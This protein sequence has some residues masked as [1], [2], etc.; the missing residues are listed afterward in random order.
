VEPPAV[1]PIGRAVANTRLYVL[2][3]RQQ[4]VPIGVPG[5]LY[6]AGV[7]VGL[8]YHHR[9][10]LTAERF[11]PDPYAPT[12]ARPPHRAARMYRTGDRARWRADG[13]VEYLGR[14]DFQ[15][16]LRGFRI[17][18]GEIESAL[19]ADPSVHSAAVIVREDVPGD[20]RLVA[21]VVP[22][23]DAEL[24]ASALRALLQARLPEYMVPSAFVF[25]ESLPLSANGKLER[26]SL[27]APDSPLDVAAAYVAPRTTTEQ[28]IA[29]VFA[30]VLGVERVGVDDDFFALGGHSLLAMRA[31][32]RLAAV[33]PQRLTI[34][35]MFEARTVARLAALADAGGSPASA[36]PDAGAAPRIERSAEQ[37]PA[38]RS[39]AQQG[40]WTAEQRTPDTAA[41]NAPMVMRLRGALDPHAL[42]AALGA[43]VARHEVLRTS[44][45]ERVGE[46][47]Q[48][49]H[50][51]VKVPVEHA[52]LRGDAARLDVLLRRTV[53]TPFAL[54][55]APLIRALVARTGD[56][57]WVVAIVAHH[58]VFDGGSEPLFKRDLAAAYDAIVAGASPHLAPLPIA[59]ADYAR[60][61]RARRDDGGLT[62]ALAYWRDALAGAPAAIDL[63]SDAP[64]QGARDARSDDAAARVSVTYPPALLDALH[65]LAREQNATMFMV[66]LAGFQALLSRFARQ[67]DLVVG[68][69][70][71][72]RDRPE[73]QQLIGFLTNTLPLRATLD[74]GTT[75]AALVGQARERL[76]G[77]FAHAGVPVERVS[78]ELGRA[79]LFDTL[80]VLQDG[81][82]RAASLAG[83]EM[84]TVA[85]EI[86]AAKLDLAL[87]MTVTNGGLRAVLI[88]R[89]ARFT[90][91]TAERLLEHLGRLL[92]SA[93]ESP[94]RAIAD[95]PLLGDADRAQ[96]AAWNDT[97]AGY[98]LDRTLPELIAETVRRSPGTIA[99][100]DERE[101]LTYAAL[102]ARASQLAVTLRANG[103]G[104]GTLVGVCAERSV[105]MVVGLLAILEAGGAYVPIDPEYPAERV[106]YMLADSDVPVLLTQTHLA[107]SLPASGAIVLLLDD[108]TCAWAS[109]EAERVE[110]SPLARPDDPA[111]MIYTSGSTGQPKGAI[112]SH[113]GIVNRLAWMQAEYGLTPDDVV[114]QKTPFSFDVSVWEFF[115]PL[116][117]GARLVLAR[118]GG[119]RDSTYLSVV[120]ARH[121]VTVCHFVPSMLRVFLADPSAT[122]A[123]AL[124][125]V[126]ASGEALAPDL[127]AQFYAVLPDARLHNLYGPTECAVDVSYWACPPS[128][129]PLNLVPIGRPVANTRLHVLDAAMRE[130]PIGVAGELHIGGVQVG[131]G[132]HDKPALTAERFVPDPFEGGSR[133]PS[134]ARL[135]K[136]GDLARWR[137][138]GTIEYL[139]RL[140]FQVKLRGFRIELGEIEQRIAAIEGVD[141]ALVTMHVDPVLGQRLVGYYVARADVV[142]PDVVATTLRRQL[143]DYMVPSA[144]V[145]LDAWPLSP[146]GKVD[147]RALPAPALADEGD[148]ARAPS[149]AVERVLCR[150]LA[151]TLGR[152]RVGV[153]SDFFAMGGHSLLATRLVT[154]A[155]KL[156]RV[157]LTLRGF[158]TA[159]TVAGLAE[160]VTA[161]VGVD[162]VERIA[163]LVEKVQGMTPE[164]R[165][166]LRAEQRSTQRSTGNS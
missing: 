67:D 77:G 17:E 26:R 59:F 82:D 16:K 163:T 114:L 13:T 125:A 105:G 133:A 96:L 30:D 107:G 153:T 55:R 90:R 60:W 120:M 12:S 158:F 124:R 111:Y 69:P 44:F 164:E 37:G 20:Q 139:G 80:F 142:A 152:E 136:T 131:L 8:G 45:E 166:R 103:V 31:V 91:E 18:L 58:L 148:S 54:G 101:R 1:V 138:D 38:P 43:V 100:E 119:H 9:P 115:W 155:S 123:I 2:D 11:V 145:R 92:A 47:V 128:T 42:E 135:Y 85:T 157:S 19:A 113:R 150:L 48:V 7:Q 104:P 64:I 106:T 144:L 97:S 63:P 53:Q 160:S 73:T 154:Q 162:R 129:T 46:A 122:A 51:S 74:A 156:F 28:R 93:A 29:D 149:T 75:F 70:V 121:R 24:S 10:E 78:A 15:V 21:Y 118:P 117:V 14:L 72:G 102:H 22:A 98:P 56:A 88:H 23:D 3:A 141:G 71:S 4:P 137:T 143:P 33:L 161:A 6:L 81:D 50:S 34:G 146:N 87:S 165:E 68:V 76:L 52:D 36:T 86:G 35:A 134:G 66:L 151:E 130:V 126:M 159:P 95:L 32:A 49:A 89:T 132:Y 127:V 140:D 25:L 110:M 94:S 83:C 112:N 99:V 41:Y 27:P 116:I 108:P 79:A 39:A 109:D 62:S 40:V 65:V 84:E 61:E 5:E 147:R 57:E